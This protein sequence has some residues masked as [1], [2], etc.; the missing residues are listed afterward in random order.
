MYVCVPAY[1]RDEDIIAK[2]SSVVVSRV[3]LSKQQQQPLASVSKTTG[4]AHQIH[5]AVTPTSSLQNTFL[6]CHITAQQLQKF[7][8][9]Q[10]QEATLMP[11][12]QTSSQL[13][14]LS[15]NTGTQGQ[16]HISLAT[17]QNMERS[18]SGSCKRKRE[19]EPLIERVCKRKVSEEMSFFRYRKVMD[20]DDTDTCNG[21]EV[22]NTDCRMEDEEYHASLDGYTMDVLSYKL[23]TLQL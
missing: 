20:D 22:D 14:A 2:D 15:T 16:Q 6:A 18:Q 8:I 3:Q 10:P 19:D 7:T 1:S 12:R 4:A 11:P 17:S 21:L 9:V 23:H 13:Q 5:T